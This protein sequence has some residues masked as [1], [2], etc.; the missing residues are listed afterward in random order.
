[1]MV[2]NLFA[3]PAH[4]ANDS[5]GDVDGDGDGDGDGSGSGEK[6]SICKQQYLRKLFGS[7]LG[8]L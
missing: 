7:P 4:C 2:I 8:G 1:M 3:R 5:D 6:G